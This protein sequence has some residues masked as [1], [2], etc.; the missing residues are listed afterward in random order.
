MLTRRPN[1]FI[2]GPT[3]C[4]KTTLA[5][6]LAS[7]RGLSVAPA[8]GWFRA[9]F[10]GS[11][12]PDKQ[13]FTDAI[14][15]FSC[16]VL[17][18]D[19]GI[20]VDHLRRTHD[21]AAGGVVVEGCRN[22]RDFAH[23]FDPRHDVA[24]VIHYP[25]NPVGASAFEADGVRL[26]D[27]LA[28]YYVR[29]G[30]LDPERHLR[31]TIT[32]VIGPAHACASDADAGPVVAGTMHA[33]NMDHVAAFVL[34]ARVLVSPVPAGTAPQRGD[35]HC[36]VAPFPV[37]VDARYLYDMDPAREGEWVDASVFAVS[38]YLGHA[39]T[40]QVL[41]AEGAVFSYLPAQALRHGDGGGVVLDG[42]ELVYHD[43]HSTPLVAHRYEA[44]ATP[45]RAFIRQRSLWLGAAYHCTLDWYE[46]NDLLHLLLL[47]NGQVALLPSHK[48]L[49]GDGAADALPRYRKLHAEF[50]TE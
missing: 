43:C 45:A 4:G 1:V 36:D 12:L 23:L 39:P 28:G 7:R 41:T 35:V 26:I 38:S 27:D 44:L 19:P 21:L 32:S 31:F 14:T 6:K 42:P 48:V 37:R 25:Q 29:T 40:F 11:G 13:S 10:D 22:P 15:A 20:N 49:F 34:H 46:G 9:N 50:R 18:R 16:E 5:R 24:V 17:G 2:V 8:S 30:M 3:G 47:D 33:W